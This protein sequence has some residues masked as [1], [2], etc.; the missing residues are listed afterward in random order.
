MLITRESGR[1]A[2]PSKWILAAEVLAGPL[3]ADAP[4][5]LPAQPGLLPVHAH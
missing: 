1:S 4:P 5:Q 2:G 3:K